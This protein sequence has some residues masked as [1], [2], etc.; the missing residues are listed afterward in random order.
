MLDRSCR[1]DYDLC[2]CDRKLNSLRINYCNLYSYCITRLTYCCSDIP[3]DCSVRKGYDRTCCCSC[4]SGCACS[5]C[6]SCSHELNIDS[7]VNKLNLICDDLAVCIADNCV[8]PLYGVSA[9]CAI[10]GNLVCEYKN[11]VPFLSSNRIA[12]LVCKTEF[13]SLVVRNKCC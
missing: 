1:L 7:T 10:L 2:A 13:L 4:C 9:L 11:L 12:S 3:A 5:C 6:C 8:G